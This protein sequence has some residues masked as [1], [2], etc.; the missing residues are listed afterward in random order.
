MEDNLDIN[1]ENGSVR[2]PRANPRIT[3]ECIEE[4]YKQIAPLLKKRREAGL[5]EGGNQLSTVG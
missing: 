3:F 2:I 5:A 4:I 1:E